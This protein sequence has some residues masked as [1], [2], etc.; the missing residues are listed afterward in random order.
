MSE[1]VCIVCVPTRSRPGECP[2]LASLEN[3]ALAPIVIRVQRSVPLHSVTLKG[4]DAPH[5][6]DYTVKE[7]QGLE[8][9]LEKVV[10]EGYS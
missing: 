9:G 1:L 3:K 2:D 5:P 8:K 6:K 7:S 10:K 4:T